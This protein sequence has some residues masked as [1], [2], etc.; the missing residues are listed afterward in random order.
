MDLS[1]GCSSYGV[2]RKVATK[3]DM[4]GV[5]RTIEAMRERPHGLTFT[6]LVGFDA[7]YGHRRDPIGYAKALA[8][9]DARLPE[10]RA[11]LAPGDVLMLVSDQG[12]DPTFAGTDHTRE[13]A[14]LLATG[15]RVVPRP[16]PTRASCADLGATVA[17]LLGVTWD[18]AG[19]SFATQLVRAP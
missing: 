4:D 15:D 2:D 17:E 7:L 13:H 14:L 19:A 3:D 6:N 10:L 16:I 11:A 8:E 12:N 18:G 9:F 5:D 1:V